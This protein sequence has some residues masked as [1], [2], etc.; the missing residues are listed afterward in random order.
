MKHIKTIIIIILGVGVVSAA[1]FYMT[2]SQ[3]PPAQQDAVS[4][5]PGV[6]KSPVVS[7][8]GKSVNETPVVASAEKQ[9]YESGDDRYGTHIG[10]IRSVTTSPTASITI[11]YIQWFQPCGI[12]RSCPKGY[13]IANTSTELRTFT[14]NKDNFV[15]M[16]TSSSNANG[17]YMPGQITFTSF[18][19]VIQNVNPP[20]SAYD[21]YV[22]TIQNGVVTQI[23][24]VYTP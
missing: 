14:V 23:A 16:Q 6:S 12:S 2:D 20:H 13:G 19:N 17:K 9:L 22:I 3:T 8:S 10:Y 24:E 18:A 15:K 21:P 7:K 5:S 4:Q 11:D 1:Y